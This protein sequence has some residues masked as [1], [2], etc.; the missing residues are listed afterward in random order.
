MAQRSR[1]EEI[2]YRAHLIWLADGQPTGR[3]KEHWREAEAI[4]DQ[5]PTIPDQEPLAEP[6][7][8]SPGQ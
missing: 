1:E 2:R 4:V 8:V 7:V 6:P 3:D 5:I